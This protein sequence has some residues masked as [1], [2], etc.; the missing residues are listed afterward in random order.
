MNHLLNSALRPSTRLS[1]V[2]TWQNFEKFSMA[3]NYCTRLP[4]NAHIIALYITHLWRSNLKPS[5]IRTY[6]SAISYFHKINEQEDPTN[7]YFVK[8]VLKGATRSNKLVSKQ[9]KPFSKTLLLR[10]F[11][12]IEKLYAFRYEQYLYKALLSLSYYA[13]LRAG[14]AVISNSDN[15]TLHLDNI[16]IVSNNS[17]TLKFKSYKHCNSPTTKFIINPASNTIIC[18][19]KNL[20]NFLALRPNS[21]G[22]LFIFIDGTPV[23]RTH[24]SEFIKYAVN[25]IGLDPSNYNTHSVRIGRATDLALSGVSHDII[26]R[27]GRWSSSAYLNYIRLDNF[28]L[29][30]N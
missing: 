29:P 23:T 1:Y 14:E 8:Q 5:T 25:F 21:P 30:N 20:S 11:N 27:T 7:S 24:Y 9:L 28:I 17:I 6:L 12:N 13:C 26:K 10:V 19:V 22:P 15:H 18:P 16:D 3:F 4:I 2:N